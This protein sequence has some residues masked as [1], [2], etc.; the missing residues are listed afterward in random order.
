MKEFAFKDS[1]N[2]NDLRAFREMHGLS[3][4]TMSSF[5]NVS[6]RTLEG[7]ENAGKDITGPVVTLFRIIEEYP[8][9]L[10]KYKIPKRD[11]PLRMYYMKNGDINTLIDVDIINR[12]VKFINYTNNLL[13]RAFGPKES[14]TYKELE[15]FLE[16]RC[17]PRT[18]DKIKI[19]L[20]RLGLPFYD[21]L[22]IVEKTKGKLFDDDYY[23]EI[24]RER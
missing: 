22:M 24:E 8:E 14:V 11:Y 21:P 17:F 1:I 7:W 16:S 5:L 3:R 9:L 2:G 10:E 23:I 18:R 15:E 20:D 13:D 12:K 6:S 19:E 4:V